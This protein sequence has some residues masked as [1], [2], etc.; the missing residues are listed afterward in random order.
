[1]FSETTKQLLEASKAIGQVRAELEAKKLKKQPM[2][3]LNYRFQNTAKFKIKDLS[4]SLSIG[5]GK[6]WSESEVARAAMYLGLKQ[7]REICDEDKKQAKGLMHIISIR[8][9]FNK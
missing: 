8:L 4:D 2:S 5:E 1:M 7:I 3:P 6:D 9:K